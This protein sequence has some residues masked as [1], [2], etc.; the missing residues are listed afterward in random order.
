MAGADLLQAPGVRRK[1]FLP[2]IEQS[3]FLVGPLRGE[4]G[5]LGET[6]VPC[7]RSEAHPRSQSAA[8]GL[9]MLPLHAE[10]S[11]RPIPCRYVVLGCLDPGKSSSATTTLGWRSL[12]FTSDEM[13]LLKGARLLV[14]NGRRSFYSTAIPSD[15]RFFRYDGECL[16]AVDARG[17]AAL[18]TIQARLSSAAPAAHRLQRGDVLIIDNW[19]ILHGREAVPEHNGR[20]LTRRLVNA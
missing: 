13:A 3:N 1:S 17:R 10:L 18:E 7:T 19:R 12:K 6:I 14:R 16:E 5:Q 20:R 2:P 9:D 15:E 4:L 11:H 8:H